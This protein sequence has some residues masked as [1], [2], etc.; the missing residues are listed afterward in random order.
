MVD[1]KKNER[2]GAIIFGLINVGLV[3]LSTYYLIFAFCV[4]IFTAIKLRELDDKNKP[5]FLF[6]SGLFLALIDRNLA[7]FLMLPMLISG[8][9]IYYIIKRNKTD[10][11]SIKILTL[12]FSV[13]SLA[14]IGYLYTKTGLK[15]NDLVKNIEKVFIEQDFKFDKEIIRKS[16]KTMPSLVVFF[17]LIY[18]MISLKLVRNYL[19]YKNENIRDLR[20]V[21]TI[22]IEV[23][24]LKLIFASLIISIAL[25]KLIGFSKEFIYLNSIMTLK[26]IFSINGILLIDYFVTLRKNKLSRVFN[27]F[28]LFILFSYAGEIIALIGFIDTFVN[29]RKKVRIRW[30]IN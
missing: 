8:L 18:S 4:P 19:N 5:I 28:L 15:I 1:S 27:W 25:S 24:D 2:M 7:Y 17:S 10:K 20:R 11:D 16:L 30:K 9:I 29:L 6:V 21:N 13:L 12:I 22:R 3:F 14:I 23:N 26:L